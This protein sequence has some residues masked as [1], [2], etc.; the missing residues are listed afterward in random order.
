MSFILD[1]IGIL[2]SNSLVLT[3]GEDDLIT[4]IFFNNKDNKIEK[5]LF[6]V[7]K[8]TKNNHSN[9]QGLLYEKDKSTFKTLD[10]KNLDLLDNEK[11]RFIRGNFINFE[12]GHFSYLIISNLN[13]IRFVHVEK[14]V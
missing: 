3:F 6:I 8:S 7:R 12:N 10:K 9:I 4:D 13:Q 2:N 11:I 5:L 14:S 1:P